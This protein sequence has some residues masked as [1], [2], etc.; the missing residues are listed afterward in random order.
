MRCVDISVVVLLDVAEYVH[1]HS[2]IRYKCNTGR[3][4]NFEL[5]V[6]VYSLGDNQYTASFKFDFFLEDDLL[7][8]KNQ[9]QKI[10]TQEHNAK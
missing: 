7:I 3:R 10:T 2:N 8:C 9:Q 5:K 1:L 6:V 4:L